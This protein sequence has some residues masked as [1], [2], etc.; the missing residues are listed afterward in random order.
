VNTSELS[1]RELLAR[2][3]NVEDP[4]VERKVD[5]DL[6]DCLKTAVAFANTLPNGVPGV[7]FIPVRNDGTVK[8]G[9]DL[10]LLQRKISE[11]LAG[12]YPPL[13][14]FQRIIE[15][16][17]VQ[18]IAVIVPGST[19]RPHFAGPAFVR[20]GSKTMQASAQQFER[21]IAR[22]QSL[23]EELQK[24]L[25]K[26]VS[27]MIVRPPNMGGPRIHNRYDATVVE[28][29]QWYITLEFQ[30]N[31]ERKR[32]SFALRRVLLS[33]DDAHSRV[34]VEVEA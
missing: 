2:L 34:S 10:D 31:I 25:G 12:A 17:G 8:T 22:R 24:W 33:F 6:K 16:E 28:C 5:G 21:L 23:V 26:T 18:L 3:R 7:L 4:F 9:I 20:D 11:K 15:A 14:Y 1:E 19:E 13:N 29:N 30:D 27:Y 32:E